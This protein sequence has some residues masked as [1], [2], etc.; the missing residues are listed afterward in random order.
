MYFCYRGQLRHRIPHYIFNGIDI[1]LSHAILRCAS[2][3]NKNCTRALHSRLELLVLLIAPP[4]RAILWIVRAFVHLQPAI[5]EYNMWA[6]C[7]R[8]VWMPT[9]CNSISLDSQCRGVLVRKWLLFGSSD[10][11][12]KEIMPHQLLEQCVHQFIWIAVNAILLFMSF[13]MQ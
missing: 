6:E 2:N 7:L 1:R 13:S 8:G 10:K 5:I 12:E 4:M 11:H 3:N 9:I